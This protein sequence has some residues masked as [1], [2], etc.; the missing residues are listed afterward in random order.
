MRIQTGHEELFESHRSLIRGRRVGLIVNPTSVDANLTHLV[1]RFRQESDLHLSALFGPEHGIGGAAQ[2]MIPVESDQ[3]QNT[4]VPVFSLYGHT[5]ESLRPPLSAMQDLDAIIFDIQDVGARYYTYIYTMMLAME[6]AAEAGT[7]VIVLDR[8]NP[9]GGLHIE[10]NLVHDGFDSFVGM[11][12]LSNRHGMTAGELAHLFQKE[13]NLD[14]DLKV[15][16]MKGWCREMW[17]D[18]TGLPWVLPSPNMPTLDTATVYPGLCFLEGT[19]LSEGRGTT[20]PFEFF[21]APFLDSEQ[22]AHALNSEGIAGAS[23][24]AH[25]FLPTFQKHQGE[26]CGGVQLHVTD[27]QSFRS[28]EAGVAA[29][30]QARRLAPD[31]FSWREEAYEFVDDVPAIDLL[32]GTNV[33][34]EA[35]EAG[36]STK[37]VMHMMTD[38]LDKFEE[39]REPYLLYPNHREGRP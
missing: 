11:H 6:V 4:D 28:M 34:R 31:A 5:L 19:M 13:R 36:A 38:D 17:F 2:D 24:R 10:G 39:R 3:E 26:D 29:I 30:I 9:L 8:P 25:G 35:I 18:E 7:Q 23:F 22:Y 32:F 27:R 21:G 37:D 33:I 12:P 16:E 1:T 14:V 20:R 15:I